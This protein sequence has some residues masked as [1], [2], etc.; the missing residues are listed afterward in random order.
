MFKRICYRFLLCAANISITRIY[1]S[2]F[3]ASDFCKNKLPT[4]EKLELNEL[5]RKLAENYGVIQGQFYKIH[6]FYKNLNIMEGNLRHIPSDK[7][8]LALRD[9]CLKS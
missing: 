8:I 1:I 6:H 4:S 5:T 7:K 3:S 2:E 9:K